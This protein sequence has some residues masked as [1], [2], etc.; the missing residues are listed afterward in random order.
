MVEEVQQ[1]RTASR[2]VFAAGTGGGRELRRLHLLDYS[3]T[4]TSIQARWRSGSGTRR[5]EREAEEQVP[6][7]GRNH[8][9]P[10]AA[11]TPSSPLS[12]VAL[13]SPQA[14]LGSFRKPIAR[15]CVSCELPPR[16]QPKE[17]LKE[18]CFWSRKVGHVIVVFFLSFLLFLFFALVSRGGNDENHFL[19]KKKEKTFL[20]LEKTEIARKKTP[21]L[22]F[23]FFSSSARRK[24]GRRKRTPSRGSSKAPQAAGR[25]ARED[26]PG[27]LPC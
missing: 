18:A 19:G 26:G 22:L 4:S 25:A 23:S 20:E 1:N 2:A 8:S 15:A 13:S 16:K 21:P 27:S 14:R 24:I 10:S 5:C 11:S 3:R 7:V 9:L 17:R 12:P 6:S